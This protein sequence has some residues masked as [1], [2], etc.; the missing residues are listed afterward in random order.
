MLQLLAPYAVQ[1]WVTTILLIA[2]LVQKYKLHGT[3]I[4]LVLI[5]LCIS[6]AVIIIRHFLNTTI[7]ALDYVAYEFLAG[8]G[9]ML[10]G[11]WLGNSVERDRE[12]FLGRRPAVTVAKTASD[13]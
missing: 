11:I 5:C 7:E 13:E 3:V 2:F 12:I 10:V 8:V 9:G 1:I 6:F 4:D